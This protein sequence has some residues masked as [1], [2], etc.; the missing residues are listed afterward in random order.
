MTVLKKNSEGQSDDKEQ[1]LNLEFGLIKIAMM[2]NKN[3]TSSPGTTKLQWRDDSVK[4]WFCV[5][6]S[7]QR[8]LTNLI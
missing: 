8:L 2:Y 3:I 1:E 6:F 5:N 4:K 7:F